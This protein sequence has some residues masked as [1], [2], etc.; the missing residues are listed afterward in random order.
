LHEEKNKKR[1]NKKA[2]QKPMAIKT[3][4]LIFILPPLEEAGVFLKEHCFFKREG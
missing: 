1:K 3:H 2:Q 4:W